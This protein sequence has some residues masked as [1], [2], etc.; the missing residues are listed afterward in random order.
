MQVKNEDNLTNKEPWKTEP[1]ELHGEFCKLK[2]RIKRNQS[3]ALCGYVKLPPDHQFYGIDYDN[4]KLDRLDTHGGLTYGQ[5]DSENNYE[6]GFDCV[7]L[8]DLIPSMLN[9][10]PES[11]LIHKDDIYRDMNYVKNKCQRMCWQL[12]GNTFN[13]E[14]NEA[15][16]EKYAKDE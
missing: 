7:H 13:S 9:L 8:G 12:A 10:I 1:N 11:S 3:G 4:P 2:W 14:L 6:L 5:L 15:L 16:F